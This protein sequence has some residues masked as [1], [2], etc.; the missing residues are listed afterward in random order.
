MDPVISHT[1]IDGRPVVDIIKRSVDGQ[2]VAISY[3]EFA[4]HF[5][6]L[7]DSGLTREEFPVSRIIK[8]YFAY[9]GEKDGTSILVGKGVINPSPRP[10]IWL[11]E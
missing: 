8:D 1:A 9:Y 7:S 3:S 4:R 10:I 2:Y 5:T 6:S 11:P